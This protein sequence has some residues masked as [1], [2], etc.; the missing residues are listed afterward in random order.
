MRVLYS[1]PDAVG[2]PGIGWVAFHQVR[3][4]VD[5][6][7]EVILFC[8]SMHSGFELRRT[9]HL[10]TTMA[11]ARMRLPH[12]A[13]GIDRSFRY[14]DWRVARALGGLTDGVDLIHCWPRAVIRSAAVANKMNLPVLREVPNTHTAHA[15]EVVEREHD[16][17]GLPMARGQSHAF[18]AGI[19]ALEEEEYRAADLLLVPSPVS[20]RTFLD[21]GF[22]PDRLALHGYGFDPERF[23]PA[24]APR[25]EDA[26][27]TVLFAGRCEPRKG[28]HHALSAW[29]E[30]GL[31]ERGRLVV[32]GE[33]V[34][35]YR[36]L[37]EPLLS[38]PSVEWR[39]FVPDLAAAMRE[40]DVFLL[41]SIE[42]GSALVTYAAQGCGCVPVVSDAAG[43][44]CTHLK[45]GLVHQ[46]GDVRALSEHLRM[47]DG[48]RGLLRRLRAA[49]L[50]K[51]RTLT[52]RDATQGLIAIYEQAL[53]ARA[54]RPGPRQRRSRPKNA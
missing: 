27:L 17:L 45:D 21:R 41:P 31:A 35:G 10:V 1:F 18:D 44:R 25:S 48:D 20:G 42:E 13:L 3:G 32:C 29:H 11:I 52:W 36:E 39:G 49:T 7:V 5:A 4:L 2:K 43:A 9:R 30:S 15:F 19:L 40:A 46:T 22:A 26:P 33:F 51:A 6:G 28:L 24:P 12:R 14:H 50:Q 8:T 47:L 34:S 37:L 16:A 38:H 54:A 53:D 23:R